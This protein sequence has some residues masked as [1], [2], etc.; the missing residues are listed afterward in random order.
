MGLTGVYG[1]PM[2]RQHAVEIIRAAFDGG[3]TSS[4]PR[5]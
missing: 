5:R 3:V 4:I 1:T 2:D